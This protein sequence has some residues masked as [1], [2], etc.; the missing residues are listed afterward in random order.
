MRFIS[1]TPKILLIYIVC[2]FAGQAIAVGIGQTQ[3][4]ELESHVHVVVDRHQ[5]L[6][7]ARHV[8][9]LQQRLAR[10]LLLNFVRVLQ[11]L[12]ES[13]QGVH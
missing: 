5:L 8:G 6:R 12:L 9:L 2:M 7:Q 4:I 1:G 10:P 13:A 11:N 3:S